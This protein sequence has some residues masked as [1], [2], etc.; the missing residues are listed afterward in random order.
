MSSSGMGNEEDGEANLNNSEPTSLESFM[1]NMTRQMA[2]M[3]KNLSGIEDRIQ[4]GVA[5]ALVPVTGRLDTTTKRIDLLEDVQRTE[6]QMLE[7]RMDEI[8]DKPDRQRADPKSRATYTGT[9]SAP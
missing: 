8:T 3:N 4:L 1:L 7:L 9:A 2:I 6:L 5:E